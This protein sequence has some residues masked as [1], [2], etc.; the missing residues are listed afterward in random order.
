MYL[1]QM[2][3]NTEAM[4]ET[5]P[6]SSSEKAELASFSALRSDETHAD[7]I[8]QVGSKQYPAHKLIL[9]TASPVFRQ[10]LSGT[11]KESEEENVSL[12]ETGDCDQVFATFLDFLYRCT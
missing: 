9:T 3:E 4:V 6:D 11:W 12:T 5:S 1:F 2:G 7:V 10:M 8:L